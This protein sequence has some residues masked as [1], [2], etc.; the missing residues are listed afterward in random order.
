MRGPA[1]APPEG[2]SAYDAVPHPLQRTAGQRFDAI[3]VGFMRE[4]W[5]HW[6]EALGEVE[7]GVEEVPLL[8]DTWHG[9]SVPLSTYVGARGDTPARLVLLRRPIEH[10]AEHSADLRT[11]I[12]TVLIDQVAEILGIDPDDVHPG[13]E[14]TD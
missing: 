4:L 1:I 9:D 13:Y 7:L 12:L 14:S 2:A 8:P 5:R 3:A 6:P 10:R 11:V